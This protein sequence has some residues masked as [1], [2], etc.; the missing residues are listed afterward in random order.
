MKNFEETISEIDA[1]EE[2][3][4]RLFT[5][6]EDQTDV[7]FNIPLILELFGEPNDERAD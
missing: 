7:Q 2:I 1:R 6:N 4:E 5:I 3:R